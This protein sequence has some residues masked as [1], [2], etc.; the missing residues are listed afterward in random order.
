MLLLLEVHNIEQVSHLTL[1]ALYFW[2]ILFN[3]LVAWNPKIV[4]ISV[5][6]SITYEVHFFLEFNIMYRGETPT[7]QYK[8]TK[9]LC[10]SNFHTAKA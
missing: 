7:F 4:L 10:I 5:C 1:A 6:P 3:T 2:E 9:D 8:I